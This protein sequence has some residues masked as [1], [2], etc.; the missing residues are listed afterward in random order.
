MTK[1]ENIQK[2][3]REA[4][5]P[6]RCA[7]Y[8]RYSSEKQ[9]ESSVDDQIRKCR[10][11]AARQGWIIVEDYVRNDQAISGAMFEQRTALQSLIADAEQKPLP[12]DLLLVDST[13]RLARNAEDQLFTIRTLKFHRVHVVAVSQ[14][15]DSGHASAR[16]SFAVHGIMDEQYLED[17]GNNVRRGQEGCVESARYIAG[18]RCYGYKNVPDED[19]TKVG[20]YGRP[21]VRGVT[22]V[23]NLAEKLV[24]ERIFH[25]YVEGASFDKIAQSLRADKILPPRPP[26]RSSVPGWS[27]DSI[28]EILRNPIYIGH[29]IWKRTTSARDPKT[30]QMVTTPVPESEWV[31]SYREDYRI[32]PDDLW[33]RV[34]ARRVLRR[35]IGIRKLGGL[36]RTKRSE[37]YLFSGLLYCGVCGRAISVIDTQPKADVVRYGCGLHRYKAACTNATTVRRNNLERQLLDWLTTDLLGSG[38]IE[39]AAQLLY[40]RVQEKVSKLQAEAR[41]NAVNA[42]ALRKE[43]A[44]KKQEAWNLTDSIAAYGRQCL[45]TVQERLEA[46]EARIKEIEERLSQASEPDSFISFSPDDIRENLKAKL[47][48]ILSVLTSE[49]VIG[50]QVLRR[51]INRVVLTP[52]EVEGERVFYV[53]VEF[54]LDSAADSGVLLTGSMDASMQQYGFSTITIT[55]PTL[56]ACRVY[57]KRSHSK[58]NPG[59]ERSVTVLP[60]PVPEAAHA[61]QASDSALTAIHA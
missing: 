8:A 5:T 52:G 15:L 55:G 42:P 14:G 59:A 13:S 38:R 41:K 6:K 24:V 33:N 39:A 17:L 30:R 53:D 50:K 20:D 51:H 23:I 57:R 43:L 28:S 16:I 61:T 27:T 31:R 2:D 46:A 4:G 7:I 25:M 36:E 47:S 49:P 19:P 56:E 22:R 9:R 48:D 21:F 60:I 35:H 32:I 3:A 37:K 45:A 26:R 29:Y 44:E 40:S 11:Y 1:P 12:F 10:E 58:Q 34:Q 18:G 54:K